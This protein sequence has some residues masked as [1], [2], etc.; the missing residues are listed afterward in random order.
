MVETYESSLALSRTN[1][2]PNISYS[3][4]PKFIFSKG[5]KFLN[6]KEFEYNKFR[7]TASDFFTS[8][9]LQNIFSKMW[10]LLL[11]I[12]YKQEELEKIGP[13][14][15]Q[16]PVNVKLYKEFICLVVKALGAFYCNDDL[17]TGKNDVQHC[18]Y[19]NF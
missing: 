19:I 12:N 15:I 13:I 17:V 16:I 1:N 11:N 4:N 18:Q 8:H 14:Q 9:S 3:P 5:D 2:T 7:L 6:T 10:K